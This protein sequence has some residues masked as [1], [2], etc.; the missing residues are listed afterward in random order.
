MREIPD[1][2]NDIKSLFEYIYRYA[3][4]EFHLEYQTRDQRRPPDLLSANAELRRI[5]LVYAYSGGV[6]ARPVRAMINENHY[7]LAFSEFEVEIVRKINPCDVYD[8]H[9]ESIK[10]IKNESKLLWIVRAARVLFSGNSFFSELIANHVP[11]YIKKID[12]VEMFWLTLKKVEK[13]LKKMHLSGMQSVTSQLHFLMEL[14]YDCVKPDRIVMDVAQELG[15]VGASRENADLIRVARLLQI[16]ALNMEVRPAI[17]DMY[18]LIQGGHTDAKNWT[19]PDF[20]PWKW[21]RRN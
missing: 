12:D 1:F 8:L 5:A 9:W 13:K 16:F 14:G 21:P 18:F 15:M 2:L 20:V 7:D 6:Q 19:T 3:T 17:L 10:S 11:T 4:P